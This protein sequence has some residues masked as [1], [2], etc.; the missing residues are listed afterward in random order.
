M[1][2]TEKH[3]TVEVLLE[4]NCLGTETEEHIAL[5][6]CSRVPAVIGCMTAIMAE[7]EQFL[8]TTIQLPG[9]KKKQEDDEVQDPP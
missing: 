8:R 5:L 3:N 9:A 6:N 7:G 2:S 1:I 4:K